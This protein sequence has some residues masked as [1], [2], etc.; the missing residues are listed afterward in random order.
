VAFENVSFRYREGGD[1]VLREVNLVAEPGQTLA[2]LGAT[3]S[4]KTTL[5]NLVPRFYDV[6][7]GRVLIDG[8][9]IRRMSREWLLSHVGIVPQESVLFTGTV[10][11]NIRYGRA[12]ASDEEVTQAAKAAQ[13]HE[14]IEALAR[15][16]D[17]YVEQ[18]GTNFSGGQK[19]RLAIARAVLLN[20]RILILDDA[21]SAVDVETETR[22]HDALDVTGDSRTT[23]IVAQRISTVLRADKIVVLDRGRVIAHG[24]HEE[25]MKSSPVY[26]EIFDSQLGD[27]PALERKVASSRRQRD[28]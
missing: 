10:R 15:G 11:D 14:F 21:T 4:G 27:G 12:E 22:I 18:R 26:R 20:P 5:I 23:L 3:G 16:Y 17:T 13:A 8:I 28:D 9:D 24:T 6:T 25:L 7:S 19:Q 1:A 2:I